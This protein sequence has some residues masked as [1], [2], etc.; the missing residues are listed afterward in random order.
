VWLTW[1]LPVIKSRCPSSSKSYLNILSDR[2]SS[3]VSVNSSQDNIFAI[4]SK[5]TVSHNVI[6]FLSAVT[7]TLGTLGWTG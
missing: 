2:N 5:F 1:L 3:F 6:F 4:T 7:M